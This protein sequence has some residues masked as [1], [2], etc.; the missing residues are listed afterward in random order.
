[1]RQ[2]VREL[3]W[4][5]LKQA[6]ACLF[7][8]ILLVLILLTHFLW[9]ADCALARYDFLFLAALLVQGLLLAFRLETWDEARVILVFHMVGTVMELFKT[10]VGSWIYPEDNLIR[11][12]GVPLFSGFMYASV[13]SYF[14]RVWRLFDFRYTG[15]PPVWATVA[16][17]VAIYVNFFTHHYVWDMRYVLFALVLVVYG[18]TWIYFTPKSHRVRMPVV[19]ALFFGA[20]A[21]WLAENF[22]TFGNIWLY[23]EQLRGWQMVPLS[24]LGSWFLLMILSGVLV[25]LVQKP[26]VEPGR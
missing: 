9:P 18:R 14:A 8:A 16:L 25:S 1:M 7:G 4:F 11:L 24:K 3:W 2:A 19:A 17:S 23:P 5:A 22:S 20:C 12:A 15:Y 10:S 21:I 6:W 13:G 26:K